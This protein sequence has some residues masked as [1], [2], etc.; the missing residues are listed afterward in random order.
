[1]NNKGFAVT[2]LIYGLA[3]IGILLVNIVMATLSTSRKSVK[4]MAKV[5]EEE[6][7][8]ANRA[9]VVY[10]GNTGG[11]VN[12]TV[13]K[14]QGGLYRIE[15][16]QPQAS[17][18]SN[19]CNRERG[20]YEVG[21]IL[22]KENENIY[23][24]SG[25]CGEDTI[26]SLQDPIV[27]NKIIMKPKNTGYVLKGYTAAENLGSD[28]RIW[29]YITFNSKRYYF[30][31]A[32]HQPEV[33]S[34]E[35]KVIIEKIYSTTSDSP[36]QDL[37]SSKWKNI[38]GKTVI[39]SMTNSAASCSFYY[40]RDGVVFKKNIYT[41]RRTIQAM[42]YDAIDDVSIICNPTDDGKGRL[43]ATI[44]VASNNIVY[45]DV[46][47]KKDQKIKIQLS[48]Y[49]QDTMQQPPSHGNYYIIPY[50][51]Q[52]TAITAND[53]NNTGTAISNNFIN[54]S[55]RQ[56]WAI[57][58]INTPTDTTYPNIT[59]S[60]GKNEYRI[61]ELNS[62]RA[63]DILHDEN[64]N[65]NEISAK[66]AFNTYAKNTPQIWNIIPN[67]D[68]TYKIVAIGTPTDVNGAEHSGC[69]TTTGTTTT[70]GMCKEEYDENT[71][72]ILYPVDFSTTR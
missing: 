33:K 9:S 20:A 27:D 67:G 12:Y 21:F 15:A 1:M 18:G 68:G 65:G 10:D 52:A 16:W 3:V 62:Y 61:V 5:V 14:G 42:N 6:L 69:L 47:F 48:A 28:D 70:I 53:A 19:A 34:G 60:S 71:R 57:D 43:Q 41:H 64:R 58:L 35:G 17:S 13:P 4:D 44:G 39:P 63:L 66:S 22:L 59:N 7:I 11:V 45:S 32:R 30:V 72:Y 8:N 55:A 51:N 29:D 26:V 23:V 56:K 2:T 54:G 38:S 36:F 46:T 37:R 24:S 31:N 40:S 50:S 25:K 49:Q